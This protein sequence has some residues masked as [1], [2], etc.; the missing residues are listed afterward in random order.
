MKLGM[1]Q[2]LR[3]KKILGHTSTMKSSWTHPSTLKRSDGLAQFHRASS[4]KWLD[5]S[6]QLPNLFQAQ[7]IWWYTNQ[8]LMDYMVMIWWLYDDSMVIMLMLTLGFSHSE[9]VTQTST[10]SHDIPTIPPLLL[11]KFPFFLLVA[12][13]NIYIIDSL[14]IGY[15]I[16]DIRY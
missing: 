5:C 9:V 4:Q 11:V 10:T 1:S 7:Y 13:P 12:Y 6:L 8:H 3:W 2:G 16:L 15:W 14:D